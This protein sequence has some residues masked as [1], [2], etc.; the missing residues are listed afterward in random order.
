MHANCE[1]T[2][3]LPAYG[4]Q[5]DINALGSVAGAQGRAHRRRKRGGSFGQDICGALINE[6]IVFDA[7]KIREPSVDALEAFVAIDKC[8]TDGGVIVESVKFELRVRHLTVAVGI[9]QRP[10]AEQRVGVRSLLNEPNCP[11]SLCRSMG[12]GGKRN[13]FHGVPSRNFGS[14]APVIVTGTLPLNG[15]V[16]LSEVAVEKVC[17]IIVKAREFG[18]VV[19]D[20]SDASN[21]SDD[22]FVKAL[23]PANEK[24]TRRELTAFINALNEDEQTELVALLF[25]GRGDYTPEE[26]EDAL[27]AA[28]DRGDPPAARY[29][30]GDPL[31]GDLLAD[32]LSAFDLSCEDFEKDR[33]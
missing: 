23:T 22:R 20:P 24:T 5:F 19:D 10:N 26:W 33:L 2:S 9:R 30:L 16:M 13:G 4:T 6:G 31:L 8:Q 32:G 27:A 14:S 11:A 21:P 17:F 7:K 1:M 18:A 15:T 25:V 29:L 12:S 3:L 28:R